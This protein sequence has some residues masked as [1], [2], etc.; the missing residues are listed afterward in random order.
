M[1]KFSFDPAKGIL[2]VAVDGSW[3]TA[4]VDRYAREAGPAFEAAREKEGF[5]RLF[6]DL[7]ST[8]VLSQA[9]MDPLAKA[10]MQYSRADDRVALV[11]ASTLL[12]LQMRRMLGEAPVPIFLSADEGEAWL[13]GSDSYQVRA[14]G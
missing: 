11:V 14:A 6:I 2:T 4:E 3:T 12:K 9:L 7:R 5:L 1:F 13:R 10:G 8:H